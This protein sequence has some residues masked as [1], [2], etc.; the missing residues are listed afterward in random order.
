MTVHRVAPALSPVD[1]RLRPPGSKSITIRA[2]AAAA[3][4][5]GTSEILFPLEADDTRAMRRAVS[6]FG[7]L[8]DD[9]SDPWRIG[10][11]GGSPHPPDSVIDAGESGLTARIAIAIAAL[12]PATTVITGKGRLPERPMGG[13]LEAIEALGAETRHREGHLP[14]EVRGKGTIPGGVVKVDCSKT[15]Q[16]ATAMVLVAPLF[17]GPTQIRLEGLTGSWGYLEVTHRVVSAFGARVEVVDGGWY[18][19]PTGY[20]QARLEVE[21]DASAAAYPLVAA[22][23]TAGRAEIEGIRLDSAQPDISLVSCLEEMGCEVV[24]REDRVILYGTDELSPIDVDMS[25]APDAS[26]ALAVACLFARG[27]SR[28]RG[29]G[30]LRHK[31]SD[32]LLALV[33]SFVA[34]GAEAHIEGDDLVVSPRHLRG[35]V[36]DSHGDHRIAMALALVGLVVPGVGIARPEVVSKTWPEYW[37]VLEEM[38]REGSDG[39]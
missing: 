10:G 33:E 25:A 34:L 32:R 7:G 3:L 4:A 12:T 36:L 21:P 5:P 19:E 17:D 16:F 15:S 14:V 24:G 26:L 22:A 9:Y 29:L 35:T 13:L 6:A 20:R 2:L 1:V 23:I 37:N 8:V 39:R 18:V 28:I 11:V 31:E 38:A 30:S 27:E